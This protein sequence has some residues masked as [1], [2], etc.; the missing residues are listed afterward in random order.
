MVP[1]NVTIWYQIKRY[2]IIVHASWG[3]MVRRNGAL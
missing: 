3:D 1:C 2:A